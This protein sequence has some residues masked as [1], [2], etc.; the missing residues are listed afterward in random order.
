MR[1]TESEMAMR[2]PAFISAADRYECAYWCEMELAAWRYAVTTHY[3]FTLI[4]QRLANWATKAAAFVNLKAAWLA[5][6]AYTTQ[7]N[8]A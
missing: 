2:F 4:D 6:Q 3:R 5:A 8:A 1:C 7:Q